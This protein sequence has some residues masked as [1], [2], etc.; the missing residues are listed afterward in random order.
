MNIL[1]SVT[2]EGLWGNQTPKIFFPVDQNVN[3]LVG[4]NGTGKTT[5]IN[6]IA[7]ALDADFERLDKIQFDK[8]TL[9]LK[10]KNSSKTPIIELYK[11]EKKDVPYYDIEYQIKE[12]ARGK[13][14]IFDLD[15]AAEEMHFRGLPPRM[16]RDKYYHERFLDIKKQLNS[17]TN[18][19]WLSV[20]RHTSGSRNDDERR[21]FISS[22]D[23]K[24][25]DLNNQVVKYFSQLARQYSDETRDFQKKVFLSLLTSQNEKVI[26]SKTLTIDTDLEKRALSNVFEVLNVEQSIYT[27]SLNTHF[28]KFEEARR[29]VLEPD[30][31][32]NSISIRSFA[33][34]YNTYKT[35]NLVQHYE[36]LE[37]NKKNIFRPRDTFFSVLNELFDGRK[38]VSVSARNEF[39]VTAKDGRIIKLDE[40]SSGEKQLIIILSEALLQENASIIYIADEPE[41]SLHVKWQERLTSSISK[42]NPNAQIIFATHSPDI[43][44]VYSDKVINMEVIL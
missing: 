15:A 9:K 44:S 24:L 14:K 3:F 8:V 36:S 1:K 18:L 10:A 40:L 35:H 27:K 41:L 17:M 22:V 21:R 2:I 19:C 30:S 32:D 20:H 11:K 43:V 28:E 34:L 33:A 25:D 39:I 4:Q 23:Q 7:A 6:L 12:S 31:E 16:L 42:L 29:T 5:V 13:P 37:E 26:Y 38:T